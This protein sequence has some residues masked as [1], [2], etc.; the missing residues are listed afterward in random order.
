M[1]ET[2]SMNA[3]IH[4]LFAV[5]FALKHYNKLAEGPDAANF[6]EEAIESIGD[7]QMMLTVAQG[8]LALAYEEARAKIT[9][10]DLPDCEKLCAGFV[11]R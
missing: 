11:F 3:L 2:L 4:S 9:T 5:E 7:T 10:Q 8:E 6:D 1:E